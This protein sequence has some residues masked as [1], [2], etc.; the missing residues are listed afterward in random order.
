MSH[1][2]LQTVYLTH[3]Q[4]TAFSRAHPKKK[5]VDALEDYRADQL[6]AHLIDHCLDTTGVTAEQVDDVSVGCAL[7]VKEQWS[8]GG[9][10]PAVAKPSGRPSQ[11]PHD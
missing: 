5:S 10:Y 7:P 3:Y 9:R 8:F 6:F 11:Q 2:S 4:R 1:T